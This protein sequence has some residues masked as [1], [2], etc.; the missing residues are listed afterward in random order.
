[1]KILAIDDNQDNLISL[2][3][4]IAESFPE[5]TLLIATS[6]VTGIEQASHEDPDVILLDILMP[7]LDGFEV[8]Q[9]L[10]ADPIIRDIPVVFL[11]ALKGDKE[12]RIRA[13]ESGGEAFL[14]KPIDEIELT[15][16]IRAMVKIKSSNIQ[17]RDEQ[18]RLSHL[19]TER[20]LELGKNQEETLKLLDELRAENELRKIIETELRE[21]EEKYRLLHESAGVGIGYY[22]PDGI[23]ISYNK[24][25]AKNMNGKPEDFRGKSIYN[26][27]PKQDADFY[28]E[29]INKAVNS[30]HSQ[31]YEDK[32]NLPTEEKWFHSVFSRIKKSENKVIGIQI[33]SSDITEIKKAEASMDKANRLYAVI[34]QINQTIV[35]TKTKEELLNEVCRIAIEY[36]EF[37]M[38]WLGF[39]DEKTQF[40]N[41]S[42]ISGNEDGYLSMIKKISISN[43]PEGRGPTGTAIRE[44]QHF[45][46]NDIENDPSMA[47]WKDEALKRGYYSSIAL[48]IKQFGKVIGAFSLYSSLPNFFDQQEIS[49][50]IKVAND[51]SYAIDAIETEKSHQQ[52]LCAL[53]ESEAKFR[54]LFT[55]M[56]EGFA[57]HEVIYDNNHCA[58]DYRILDINPAFEKNVGISAQKAKGALASKLYG[59]SPAPYLDVYAAVA[60]TGERQSFLTYFSPLDRHFQISVFSPNQGYFATIFT[61]ITDQKKAEEAL[62]DQQLFNKTLIENLPG[63]FYLYSYPD[64]KILQWNKNHETM[65]GITAQ[66][67]KNAMTAKWLHPDTRDNIVSAMHTAAQ[68]GHAQIEVSFRR[69][70]GTYIPF[71]LNGARLVNNDQLFIMGFGTD[72]TEW[73]KA[74]AALKESETRL[75][76]LNATKDKFFSIIAHDLKSP[77]NSIMGLSELLVEQIRNQD[78]E[79]IEEYA[80]IIQNS[81]KRAMDLL[82]NLLEWS[83]SQTGRM[84]F[85]PEYIELVSLINEA[86][87]LANDPAQQKTITISKE[88]PP[89]IIAYA[90]KSMVSAILR[91]LLSNAIKFTRPGGAIKISV[92][93]NKTDLHVCVNDNGVG[94]APGDINKLF[95]LDENHTTLG[96]KNEKGTGL[97]LI[98]CKE[99]I[100]KHNGKIWIESKA[101]VGS[102]FYFTIPNH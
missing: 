43:T 11:T 28:M 10:K 98:L 27:F 65:L 55:Q 63:I 40:V 91:N 42:I 1:M 58:V 4:L 88:L 56:T 26:L 29:R 84:E 48:P 25:A 64:M 71:I 51:I 54:G 102:Q 76:E 18:K 15:V 13:I 12:S 95:R 66:E 45:V 5:A 75:R 21:S 37:R 17:K 16:Q 83:R 97:G 39:I 24:V 34:S 59:I 38:A 81:S 33:V 80:N 86:I 9:R 70:D 53:E 90:D 93:K 73:K 100:E 68:K 22:T 32:V 50:L 87:E 2:K 82:L 31:S 52:A 101:G 19:V 30:E 60:Q 8:C 74:E 7:D 23:V 62:I 41:P 89:K 92:H 61:D 94:I 85:N 72:I 77:F 57:L 99:F 6:G 47:V 14:S 96:T 49:L 35:R 46:C 79:G 67:L 20:T 3:A 44:G 78:Y 36:G 69:K